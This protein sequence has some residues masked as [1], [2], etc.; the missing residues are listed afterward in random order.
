MCDEKERKTEDEIAQEKLG[1]VKG[2]PDLPPAPMTPQQ[3]KN[4]PRNNDPGHTA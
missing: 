3:R 1:G 4:T 2:S